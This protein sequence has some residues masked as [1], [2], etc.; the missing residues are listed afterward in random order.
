MRLICGLYR[1]DGVAATPDLV[2]AMAEGMVAPPL[3]PDI[4]L[5]AEGAVGL[6]VIDFGSSAGGRLAEDAGSVLAADRRLDDPAALAE[7]LGC[8]AD[9]DDLL[10]AAVA[11]WGEAAPDRILGDFAFA[12][13]QPA[14]GRLLCARDPFG[15]RPFHYAWRPGAWF[16][17]AS[18]PSGLHAAGLVPR[19][20]DRMALARHLVQ[21]QKAEESLF[22]GVTRLA[23][24]HVLQV[25]RAGLSVRRYW[26]PETVR[27]QPRITPEAAAMQMR[28]RLDQAVRS[29]LPRSGR[30]VGAHL[31]GGLDSSAISVLAARDLAER[32]GRLHAWS[33]LDVQRNDVVLEDEAAHVQSVLDQ[34]PGIAWAPVRLPRDDID[35]GPYH[36]DLP[37]PLG[38]ENPDCAVCVAAAAA[39]IEVILSGWGGDEAATFNGR[40]SLA[41]HFVRGRWRTLARELSA[42]K[43]ER[44]TPV[45]TAIRAEIVAYLTPGFVGAARAR[46]R[47]DGLPE[48]LM[49]CL[50]PDVAATLRAN[51]EGRLTLHPD[52]R[53]N[54]LSLIGSPHVAQRC[55]NWAAL[56]AHHGIAF[57]F[58]MLDRRLVEFALSLPGGL[59]QRGGWKRR[60]FRDA[61]R[62][63]LPDMI[64]QRHDK[65]TPF[66]STPLVLAEQRER[67]AA[68][69]EA[70]ASDTTVAS[71]F[72]LDRLR[73]RAK[74]LPAPETLKGEL[75]GNATPSADSPAIRHPLRMAA[76]LAQG[77]QASVSPPLQPR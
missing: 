52:D 48:R 19:R 33:F 54:R 10:S 53:R 49:A 21:R 57:A 68:R 6:G 76:F 56:G 46:K 5:W 30:A 73:D 18:F 23:A 63:V 72:D 51:G 71:L 16:A 67:L 35:A 26:D 55:E 45:A 62:G 66:P 75:T 47:T 20:F 61:M 40:G 22:V 15:V 64:R 9:E 60:V 42:I 37:L 24:A 1:F 2:S 27:P 11:R 43:R 77:S 14:T 58:P 50:A 65:A 69:I 28:S 41:E 31:S 29:R 8:G 44:G 36:A 12:H 3:R 38:P 70:A 13:W 39:G 17:F 32:G 7:V 25:S 34:E 74:A 59:F 4:R